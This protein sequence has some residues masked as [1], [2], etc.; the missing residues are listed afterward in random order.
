[1]RVLVSTSV[2]NNSI[3]I[4]YYNKPVV[5]VCQSYQQVPACFHEWFVGIPNEFISLKWSLMLCSLFKT[6]AVNCGKLMKH[7]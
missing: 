5:T 2:M 3:V 4:Y 1:M 6:K 7:Y